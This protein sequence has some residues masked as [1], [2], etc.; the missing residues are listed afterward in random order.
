MTAARILW[1]RMQCVMARGLSLLVAIAPPPLLVALA[2]AAGGLAFVIWR[3]RRQIA[4]ENILQAGLSPTAAGARAMARTAF[5]TL[6]VMVVESAIIR[7]RMTRENWRDYVQLDAS[8]AVEHALRQPGQGLIVASAHLGN[9]EVAARAA[10]MLK[11]MCAIYRPFTN[12]YLDR[13]VRAHREGEGL[14]L[15]SRL[16]DSPW[17]F[18]HA[19]AHGEIVALMIDQHVVRGRV[20]VQFFGRPAWATKSV[21]MLHLTTRAPV[22]VACAVRVRPLRYTLRVVGPVTCERTGD[23]E[24]DA[25]A[26][27]QAL[28]AELEAEVR[29]YPEQYMWGHRRWRVRRE[30]AS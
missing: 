22:L 4:M 26:L 30:P 1:Y 24:K 11:P 10:S 8:P 6:A 28:T 5:Q 2:R 3:R 17:R 19:L 7:R 9:W 27:T 15:V 13:V 21:A 23:R 16:A 20:A 14:R 12:P 25:L 18:V 29:R